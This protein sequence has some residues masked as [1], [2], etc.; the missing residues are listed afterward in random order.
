MYDVGLPLVRSWLYGIGVFIAVT[1]AVA[2]GFVIAITGPPNA[3]EVRE[4]GTILAGD[5]PEEV[6]AEP[7]A[8]PSVSDTPSAFPDFAP[9][10]VMAV[11]APSFNP[12]ER[13]FAAAETVPSLSGGADDE[14]R[15]APERVEQSPRARTD[16][17]RALA[18]GRQTT[19]RAPLARQR[20]RANPPPPARPPI[21]VARLDAH[22]PLPNAG[23]RLEELPE[24]AVPEITPDEPADVDREAYEDMG[25]RQE[26]APPA[27]EYEEA[28]Y[29]DDA[30]EEDGSSWYGSADY[31][32]ELERRRAEREARWRE[33]T[34][35]RRAYRERYEGW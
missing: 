29:P 18:E 28:K 13:G 7:V 33:R 9:D 22:A 8:E 15:A 14:T 31:Y 3:A 32:E 17:P 30:Y 11:P 16:R 34:E 21:A 20:V 19:G 10:G 35:R 2:I 25:P 24:A 5:P 27:R 4:L 1:A 12:E 26:E 6:V 23:R